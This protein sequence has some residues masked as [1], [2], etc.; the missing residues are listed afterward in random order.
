MSSNVEGA[1]HIDGPASLLPTTTIATFPIGSFLENLA[2][3]RNGSVLV[4]SMSDGSLY[5]VRPQDGSHAKVYSWDGYEATGIVEDPV[6]SDVFYVS[7]GKGNERGSWTVWKIDFNAGDESKPTVSPF[8]DVPEALW[9][10]GS[11]TIR[12]KSIVFMADS[13]QGRVYQLDIPTREACVW[14][15]HQLLEKMTTRPP[16]PG[17]NGLDVFQGELYATNSDRGL[18]LKA[19]VD[20]ESGQ[21]VADSLEIIQENIIGDDFAFDREGNLYMATNPNQTILKFPNRGRGQRVRVA[22][23][24]DDEELTG[25]TAVCFGR[26]ERDRDSIFVTTTGGLVNPTKGKDGPGFARLVR[27]DVGVSGNR[28]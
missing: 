10:N 12:E 23:A 5:Q 18:L 26:T 13:L 8:V 14:L 27:V 20:H 1:E 4:S 17:V 24:V 21:Y 16:W 28:S 9:L 7:V 15:S 3:R 2:F 11:T 6:D 19:S 22:G 25:A